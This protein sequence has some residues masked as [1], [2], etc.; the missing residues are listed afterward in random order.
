MVRSGRSKTLDEMFIFNRDYDYFTVEISS[1]KCW[2]ICSQLAQKEE[3]E[4]GGR[5]HMVFYG[6]KKGF[7]C[8]FFKVCYWIAHT[9]A[10]KNW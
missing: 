5:R 9:H 4:G 8:I 7:R 6:R 1:K 10:F 2:N 3:G